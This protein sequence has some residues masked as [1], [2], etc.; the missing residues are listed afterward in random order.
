MNRF[1]FPALAASLLAACATTGTAPAVT[2]ASIVAD[3]QGAVKGLQTALTD[4]TAA[5]PSLIPPSTVA[6][7]TADLTDASSAAAMLA[8]NMP[9]T[10]GANSASVVMGDIND[11]LNTLA[12]PPVNG[13]IPAPAN[14]IVAAA[15]VV[16]PVIE[17]YVTQYL[18]AKAAA[19]PDTINARVLLAAA[20]PMSLAQAREVLAAQ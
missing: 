6:R 10:L 20:H 7:L 3:V 13:L 14:E 9:A 2:P 5:N 15:A 4:I 18:P 17:A 12:A 8:A 11:V 1:L 16:A 19:A